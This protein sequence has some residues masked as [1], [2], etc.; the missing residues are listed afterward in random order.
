[1]YADKGILMTFGN[2]ANG[3]LGHGNYDDVAEVC[4]IQLSCD[5]HMIT[6]LTAK[7]GPLDVGV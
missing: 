4:I 1:M 2:G 3:S 7:V 6:A 5:N